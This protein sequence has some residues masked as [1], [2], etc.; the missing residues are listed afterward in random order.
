M[1]VSRLNA[2]KKRGQMWGRGTTTTKKRVRKRSRGSPPPSVILLPLPVM[3]TYNF[4]Q[5]R[6]VSDGERASASA[7]TGGGTQFA[8]SFRCLTVG[9][10]S[11]SRR[12]PLC[13]PPVPHSHTL[14]QVSIA[15]EGRGKEPAVECRRRPPPSNHR[16][17]TFLLPPLS[18]P[19]SP[20]AATPTQSTP[21]PSPT[22]KRPC[23]RWRT[24]R[25]PST[26]AARGC[27]RWTRARW[28]SCATR[29][30]PKRERCKHR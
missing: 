18:L 9:A 2:K 6:R 19:P 27:P 25:P 21:S 26:R 24:G 10:L 1:P 30:W 4:T 8:A 7:T 15:S 3:A 20:T 12:P 17:S 11:L 23:R 13:A 14:I 16:V 5:V 29:R 28:T 22:R